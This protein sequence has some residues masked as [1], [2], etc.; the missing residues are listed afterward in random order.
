MFVPINYVHHTV[1][2]RN[3][4]QGFSIFTFLL[5]NLTFGC[6]Q[7]AGKNSHHLIEATFKAFAR[8][9]RQATE[10]DPRRL[11]TVPRFDINVFTLK[12]YNPYK[13]IFF[14]KSCAFLF[15]GWGG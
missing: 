9:L 1:F 10:Y 12:L 6:A 13:I 7:L 15:G 4:P 3:L 14:E 5:N 11:G 2:V 8:A